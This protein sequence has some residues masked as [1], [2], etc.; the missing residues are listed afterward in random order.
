MEGYLVHKKSTKG[1]SLHRNIPRQRGY[2][3]IAGV[4]G[5]QPQG[6]SIASSFEKFQKAIKIYIVDPFKAAEIGAEPHVIL[7]FIPTELDYKVTSSFPAIKLLGRNNPKYHYGGSE[8]SLSFEIDWYHFSRDTVINKC[9]AI[10]ALTKADGYGKRPPIV[11]I[12]WGTGNSLFDKH[13]FIVVSAPY[14]LS[15]F[16][17]NHIAPNEYYRLRNLGGFYPTYGK[18]VV[19]LKR[20]TSH[21]LTWKEIMA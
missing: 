13:F 18:Q 16:S 21:S 19:T 20:I 8:D 2:E 6:L 10:E 14:K 4:E 7:D 3:S 15:H 9:R 17:K 11:Y 5:P 1:L 12:K